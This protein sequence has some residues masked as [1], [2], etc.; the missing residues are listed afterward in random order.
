MKHNNSSRNSPTLFGMVK[1]LFK[2]ANILSLLALILIVG[3]VY[4][5]SPDAVAY[6]LESGETITY[7]F[8]MEEGENLDIGLT[9]FHVNNQEFDFR[10]FDNELLE[11]TLYKIGDTKE[12]IYTGSSAM[13]SGNY[14]ATEGHYELYVL[15]ISNDYVG[16]AVGHA[17]IT[18]THLAG[19]V[20]GSIFLSV[21]A[22]IFGIAI[23]M[24]VFVLTVYS[25]VYTLRLF[26]RL[27]GRNSRVQ[28]YR[29]N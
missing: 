11:M 29:Q 5:A 10:E 27:D 2:A 18:I 9:T 28:Y 16:F 3:S 14:I 25:F 21:A 1:P 13:W 15:N 6:Q 19:I 23:G 8:Y 22:A 12:V 26:Q 24:T 4:T 20:L 7:S 17:S